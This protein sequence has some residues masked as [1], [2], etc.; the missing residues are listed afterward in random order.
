M[1]DQNAG[2]LR[3][4]MK[5]AELAARD[6]ARDL[7]YA[8]ESQKE[9]GSELNKAAKLFKDYLG[10]SN[11]LQ[12]STKGSLKLTQDL[13]SLYGE[14]LRIKEDLNLK[15]VMI[16]TGLKGQYAQLAAT[17]TLEGRLTDELVEELLARQKISDHASEE[18]ELAEEMAKLHLEAREEL[19]KYTK[20]WQK[21]KD[22]AMAIAKDPQLNKTV[23]GGLL[24]KKSGEALKEMGESLQEFRKD[25]ES[26]TQAFHSLGM[27]LNANSIIL[28]QDTK[29]ALEGLQDSMGG[30]E[31]IT[32]DTVK[33]V[34]GLSQAFGATVQEAGLLV[35]H[36]AQVPGMTQ[37]SAVH[38]AEMTGRLAVSAGVKP[39]KVLEGMARST[40]EMA[41]FSA[42]GGESF[43]RAAVGAAKMGVDVGKIASAAEN[44]L[45][46]ESSITKQMEASVLL[47]REI[48]LDK[49]RELSL[50]GDLAG[51]T[52]EILKNIGGEAEFNKMNLLQ[53]K[54]LAESIGVSVA[55]LGKM[56]KHQEDFSEAQKEALQQGKGL[57]E[58]LAMGSGFAENLMK[59]FTG[60]NLVM[61]LSG[62]E[63]MKNL[64]IF[65]KAASM[66]QAAW[67]S[68]KGLFTAATIAETAATAEQTVV[69]TTNTV[70]T[71]NAGAAAKSSSFGF[72]AFGKA[73][74]SFGAAAAGA[75]IPMLAL[76]ASV[77]L[78]GAGVAVA[79]YGI[80]LMVDSFAKMPYDNLAMLPLAMMGIGAGLGL[81]AVA[82]LQA[83]PI[84]GMLIT[85]AA[86]SPALIKLA[87]SFSGLSGAGATEGKGKKVKSEKTMDDV[88]NVITTLAE[89]IQKQPVVVSV[90]G[91]AVI[92][93]IRKSSNLSQSQ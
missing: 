58:V 18:V 50:N 76:G 93:A 33:G 28:G 12:E 80:S 24:I 88:V 34:A 83:I 29:G 8:L 46:F 4:D 52:G 27:T 71:L 56:V 57:D 19:E 69:T 89:N 7:N 64:G 16:N 15:Q 51:A 79:A 60:E 48:N 6:L 53:R 78:V 54:A 70:A 55:D 91:G 61:L 43:A 20:G 44:L 86:V 49:A 22:L 84:I 45:D 11:K 67:T 10:T 62:W 41:K 37:E 31:A 3:E 26:V 82:G 36:L 77:F 81:M 63:S 14:E 9:I 68:I 38:M 5:A 73:L 85:L 17:A 13:T 42:Q 1:A 75:A 92:R 25:G 23:F 72:Q 35:G 66:A 87:D 65:T 90:D 39:G 74:G 2:K 47:G 59:S 32:E 21:T 40:E 30:I